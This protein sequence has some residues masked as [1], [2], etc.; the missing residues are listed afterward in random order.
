MFVEAEAAVSIEV[1]LLSGEIV[2][3][4]D[5]VIVGRTVVSVFQCPLLDL[6]RF[7]SVV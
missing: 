4:L 7:G 5:S 2:S 6:V 3:Q 1:C